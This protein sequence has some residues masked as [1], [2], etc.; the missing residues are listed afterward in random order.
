M[1]EKKR[2]ISKIAKELELTT[3]K[4]LDFIKS[5]HPEVDVSKSISAKVDDDI[6]CSILKKFVPETYRS[7]IEEEKPR[8]KE[9]DEK[10][11]NAQQK[12][13]GI[14][15]R[16][17][18][19]DE[20]IHSGDNEDEQP[21]E[22]RSRRRIKDETRSKEEMKEERT[23]KEDHPVEP[24]PEPEIPKNEPEPQE[25]S[26]PVTAAIPEPEED[27]KNKYTK[28]L[29]IKR[30][31]ETPPKTVKEK[32]SSVK[33]GVDSTKSEDNPKQADGKGKKVKK[34]DDRDAIKEDKAP[35]GK[36][37]FKRRRHKKVSVVVA[38]GGV[39]ETADEAVK[40]GGKKKRKKDKVS[41]E[42]V[43]DSVKETLSKMSTDTSKSFKKKK[44]RKSQADGTEIEVEVDVIKVSEFIST[45][46]LANKLDVSV[47]EIITKCFSLGMMVTINQR[48]DKETIELIAAE[49]DTEVEFESEYDEDF[50]YED[51]HEDPALLKE[52]NPIITVMGHVDHGKT[53]LLD[54][55]RNTKVVA[56][57]SG[58]IT[59]HIGAYVV[60]YNDKNLTFLDTPGHEA[61][62][63][64]RSRGAKVTDI[65]IIVIAADDKVNAQTNEAIDHALLA[66]VPIIFA[67]NK[68]DR[69]NADAERIRTQLSQRN[70]LVEQWGGK[71][72]SVEISAKTGQG[73]EELLDAIILESDML[74]LKANPSCQA[75]GTVIES[76]LDKGFGAVSTI[77][78]QKGTL[79]VGDVFVCGQTY[80]KVRAM[81]NERRENV[82]EAKPAYPVMVLGFSSSANAGDSFIVVDNEQK[83]RSIASKREQINRAQAQHKINIVTLDN[84]SEQIKLGDIRNLNLLIKADADGSVEAIGDT[85]MKMSNKEV[86]VKI[87]SKG[88][89]AITEGD[90]LLAEASDAII[91][92][93][94][95]RPNNKAKELAHQKKV[96]IR[97]YS[98]IYDLFEEVKS[99]LEGMLKP[100]ITEELLGTAEVRATFKVP[101]M[102][103]IAGSY[104]LS[105]KVIRNALLKVIRDGIEIYQG[106][107]NSLKRM[108]D[109][110]KEVVAG[111]E[112]GIGIENFNDFKEN[113]I[114]EVFEYKETQ[115]KLEV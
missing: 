45:S 80:G 38:D 25:E 72:Q 59:Q 8:K 41:Q 3:Q 37:V 67:I 51:E 73:I 9:E 18:E 108:K 103:T 34:A 20:I 23:E 100:L 70:I 39:V 65:V 77:L 40:R 27:E 82:A 7:Y 96:E 5:E 35:K 86:A 112:C 87:L 109:D 30:R 53:S 52:R 68:M 11:I 12:Q 49:F 15:S 10:V 17:S 104:V 46:E 113:D 26:E 92:G 99:A 101:K 33:A 84:V 111:Y 107:L 48:L 2:Q 36:P 54:Y 29:V 93:F 106:K 64:M 115:R 102:G 47:T 79:R 90:V 95:V 56:G 58:G 16:L 76:K 89:G 110:A 32:P 22:K 78:V 66:E 55:I 97:I 44:K 85:L 13:I 81:L 4:I 83:A 28:R 60:D 6:Y 91:L 43:K 24:A 57:E 31:S 114:I 94:H 61:F 105:G 42:E 69:P 21:K 74:E 63:A 62:T 88:V 1:K 14:K 75:I 98:I 71:Y 50:F 19:I